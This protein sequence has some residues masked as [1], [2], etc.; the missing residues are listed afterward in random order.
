[1]FEPHDVAISLLFNFFNAKSSRYIHLLLRLHILYL[2]QLL[3]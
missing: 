3:R 1:M 2:L